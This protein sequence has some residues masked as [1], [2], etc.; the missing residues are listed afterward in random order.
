MYNRMKSHISNKMIAGYI[1][2]SPGL[3]RK[4]VAAHLEACDDCTRRWSVMKRV[5]EPVPDAAHEPDR[6]ALKRVERRLIATFRGISPAAEKPGLSR[7][8]MPGVSLRS[9]LSAAAVL[10]VLGLGIIFGA[11]F[12][13]RGEK[14]PIYVYY[15][16]GVSFIDGERVAYH[17]P[18]R[19][20]SVITVE[21][22][23]ILILAYKNRFIVKIYEKSELELSRNHEGG[24]LAGRQFLFNLSRGKVYT[25]FNHTDRETRYFYLTPTAELFASGSEFI[26]HVNSHG[27]TVIPGGGNTAIRSLREK[28]KMD[29]PPDNEYIISSTI[30][31][32]NRAGGMSSSELRSDLK[33]PFS[34]EETFMLKDVLETLGGY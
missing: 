25:R 4:T 3:D 19:D 5:I 33:M 18:I 6:K 8:L 32:R 9:G 1:T 2:G 31:V 28:R 14:L 15:H 13:T 16:K 12:F 30:E 17:M 29:A 34:R 23:G 22:G 24:K 20:R 21:P 10:L 26:M 27:T 7:F 11:G